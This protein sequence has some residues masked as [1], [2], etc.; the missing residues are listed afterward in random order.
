VPLAAIAVL[1]VVG[2]VDVL[3]GLQPFILPVVLMGVG[4][5]LLVEPAHR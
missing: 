3:P 1:G 5:Y 4:A 2:G